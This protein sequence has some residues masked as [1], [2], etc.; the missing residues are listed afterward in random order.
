MRGREAF[1][2]SH[3]RHGPFPAPFPIRETIALIRVRHAPH[4]AA[5]TAGVFSKARLNP[6]ML[7]R[8]QG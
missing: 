6:S 7:Q 2:V 5:S 8:N 1:A 3:L 4:M